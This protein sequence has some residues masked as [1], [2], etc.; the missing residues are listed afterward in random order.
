VEEIKNAI[1]KHGF[2]LGSVVFV[3][4]NQADDLYNIDGQH[5]LEA[6]RQLY[7]EDP[8]YGELD[9][10]VQILPVETEDDAMYYYSLVNKNRPVVIPSE[11]FR[12]N[13]VKQIVNRLRKQFPT[14]FTDKSI[15]RPLIN[16]NEL[17]N[18]LSVNYELVSN[19]SFIEKMEAI[20][21]F[22]EKIKNMDIID[23]RK[24]KRDK[25]DVIQRAKERAKKKGGLYLGLYP[26]PLDWSIICD[27][28]TEVKIGGKQNDQTYSKTDFIGIS[29]RSKVWERLAGN[30]FRIKCPCCKEEE[31]TSNKFTI[32][33]NVPVAKGGT[34]ELENLRLSCTTCNLQCGT[35]VFDEFCSKQRFFQ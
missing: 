20:M 13:E 18:S 9:V 10:S 29:Q 28:D 19:M 26:K 16:P 27:F 12:V 34:D 8:N 3:S 31:I 33:H 2:L 5:R 35:E 11:Y 22:N 30:V 6:L 24:T 4:Y 1:K 15:Q 7:T 21:M 14:C 23:L 17:F 32:A 25:T